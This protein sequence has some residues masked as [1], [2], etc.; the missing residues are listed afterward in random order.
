MFLS[1]WGTSLVFTSTQSDHSFVSKS[2]VEERNCQ[3]FEISDK[4]IRPIYVAQLVERVHQTEWWVVQSLPLP[5]ILRLA[6]LD[7]HRFEKRP[8]PAPV[9]AVTTAI[10]VQH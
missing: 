1:S 8:G 6:Y 7:E 5:I 3:N 10:L 9:F 2:E 4:V